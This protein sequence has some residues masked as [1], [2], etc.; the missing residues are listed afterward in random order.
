[1]RDNRDRPA[2]VPVHL[3]P[4]DEELLARLG[5]PPFDPVGNNEWS[6]NCAVA[7]ACI[8][9]RNKKLELSECMTLTMEALDRVGK[10]TVK[11]SQEKRI[12]A[13]EKHLGLKGK[14][15]PDAARVVSVDR[16]APLRSGQV[17]QRREPLHGPVP[18]LPIEANGSVDPNG[19]GPVG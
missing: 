13:A 4:E 10:T 7:W 12:R 3:T 15:V 8:V 19:R 11:A 6:N 9:Q 16:G 14:P 18:E 1:M 17:P 2:L 5:D